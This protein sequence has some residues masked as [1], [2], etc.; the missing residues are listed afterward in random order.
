MEEKKYPIIIKKKNSLMV[1]AVIA[2][3]VIALVYGITQGPTSL[4][5]SC[6]LFVAVV[7]ALAVWVEYSRDIYLKENKIEFYQNKNL[8]QK[9]K[10]SSIESIDV[11]NGIEPKDRKK[12]F[13]VITYRE[14]SNKKKNNRN[15]K[16]DKY[17]LSTS[18]YCSNDFKM[19]RDAIKSRNP[20]VKL[21]ENLSKYIKE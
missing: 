16:I 15:E 7:T 12:D 3:F 20:E 14:T 6:F 17:Y 1:M 4:L 18:Y 9:I 10:Y 21:N 5:F 11:D 8:I 2:E 13:I 19:I